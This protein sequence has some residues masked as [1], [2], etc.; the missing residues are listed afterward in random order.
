MHYPPQLI[1]YVIA[2]ELAHLVEMNH[3]A[4]FWAVVESLM[5]DYKTPHKALSKMNPAEVPIL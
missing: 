4:R 2:H 3:S 1:E 5:P